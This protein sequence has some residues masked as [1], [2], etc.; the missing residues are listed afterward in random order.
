MFAVVLDT[1]VLWPSLQRDFLL[2]LAVEG[3]YRPLWSSAIIGEL[4]YHESA[5]LVAWGEDPETAR[6][7]SCHLIDMMTLRFDDACVENWESLEGTFR[8]PDPNDEHVLAAAV[9]GGAGAIVT[10]NVSDFPEREDLIPSRIKI[11]TAA[12]FAAD[13][14]AVSPETALHAIETMIVRFERPPLTVEQVLGFLIDRY[15]M[16]EAVEL[17]RSV[18]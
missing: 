18:C 5:K 17:I 10:D 8:L 2:S 14:V 1:C 15:A 7:R 11:L 3:M 12:Q 16:T 13:T 6:K 9:V 4:E